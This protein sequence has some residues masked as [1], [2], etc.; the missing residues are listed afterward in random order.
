MPKVNRTKI[1]SNIIKVI[2]QNLTPETNVSY[3]FGDTIITDQKDLAVMPVVFHPFKLE[4]ANYVSTFGF[5]DSVLS[6]TLT[7]TFK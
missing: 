3:S 5:T 7:K 1:S 2:P 4:N 6:Y